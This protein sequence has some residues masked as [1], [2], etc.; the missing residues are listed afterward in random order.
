MN[1]GLVYILIA[2]LLWATEMVIIRKFFPS[3][4]SVFL[5]AAGSVLGSLFYLPTLFIFKEKLSVQ[6]WIIMLVYAFTSW[7]LAQIFYVSGIQKGISAFAISL[8][9]LSLPL[10]AFILSA[11]FLKEALTAKTVIGGI[12]MIIGFLI[13]SI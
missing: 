10:F 2:E 8:A 9:A 6:S 7:F 5:A 1:I 4:N 3:A 12:I 11:I 13:I